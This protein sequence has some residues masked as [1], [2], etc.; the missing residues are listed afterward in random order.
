MTT[1]IVSYDFFSTAKTELVEV[2][3]KRS[4]KKCFSMLKLI[5]HGYKQF[6]YS[7]KGDEAPLVFSATFLN[8]SKELTLWGDDMRRAISTCGAEKGSVINVTDLGRTP[9]D[10]GSGKSKIKK[11]YDVELVSL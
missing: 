5:D 8:G 2:V 6:P 3:E 4:E 10:N 9:V 11:L 7:D 1:G